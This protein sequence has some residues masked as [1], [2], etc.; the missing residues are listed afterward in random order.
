MKKLLLLSA[1]LIFAC[2]SD[3]S[4]TDSNDDNS[5]QTFLERFDDYIW[6]DEESQTLDYSSL[7][8]FSNSPQSYMFVDKYNGS[9]SSCNPYNIENILQNAGDTLI[10]EFTSGN[11][12]VA[13][14]TAFNG[15]E[16]IRY[17]VIFKDENTTYQDGS[18]YYD[19]IFTKTSESLGCQ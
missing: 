6:V 17:K 5:N 15:G 10:F 2:S 13:T 14:A 16:S 4:S 11:R 3:E 18:T 9:A 1:L 19:I 7:L 8:Q 12:F